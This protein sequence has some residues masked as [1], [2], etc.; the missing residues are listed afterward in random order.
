MSSNSDDL[1]IPERDSV[2]EKLRR[3]LFGD[4]IFISY[5][6]VD[7]TY[8][9]S[10][11]N[12]LTKNK[13]SCF[14]DQ[15][16]TPPGEE[17]P[18][19]LINTIKRCSTMVLIGSKNAADSDNVGL[20]VKE[21]LETDR[22]IIPITF[23]AD[24]LLVDTP[25]DSNRQ[26]LTGTL[27]Q[28]IWYSLIAGIAKTTEVLSALK[29]R[30]P[31]ENVIL[32]IVNAAEFRSRSKR[33]RKTFFATLGCVVLLSVIGFITFLFLSNQ[34][35]A[36]NKDRFDAETN[37]NL[38]KEGLSKAQ[39]ELSNTNKSLENATAS[40]KDKEGQLTNANI[41]LKNAATER[42]KVESRLTQTKQDLA[43]AETQTKIEQAKALRAEDQRIKAE[44]ETNKQKQETQKYTAINYFNTAQKL[45]SI[46]ADRSLL[47]AQESLKTL[48][49]KADEQSLY[50]LRLLQLTRNVKENFIN[51]AVTPDVDTLTIFS[52][53][54]N[55]AIIISKNILKVWDLKKGRE[56]PLPSFDRKSYKAIFYNKFYH[57]IFSP[58]EKY[59]AFF[60]LKKSTDGNNSVEDKFYLE[61]W[62]LETGENKL[63]FSHILFQNYMVH[64]FQTLPN[65]D[66]KLVTLDNESNLPMK[67]IWRFSPDSRSILMNTKDNI[68][69]QNKINSIIGWEVDS[70]NSEMPVENIRISNSRTNFAVSPDPNHNFVVTYEKSNSGNL[71]RFEDITKDKKISPMKVGWRKIQ[72]TPIFD[73]KLLLTLN[74][75]NEQDKNKWDQELVVHDLS[76]GEDSKY[77]LQTS[78]RPFLT[79]PSKESESPTRD[80]FL[81]RGFNKNKLFFSRECV[82]SATDKISKSNAD[83]ECENE[84]YIFDLKENKLENLTRPI[85]LGQKNFDQIKVSTFDDD[86][87]IITETI[88]NDNPSREIKVW[89]ATTGLLIR[90]PT[91]RRYSKVLPQEKSIITTPEEG[92][93]EIESILSWGREPNFKIDPSLLKDDRAKIRLNPDKKQFFIV[94]KNGISVHSLDNKDLKYQLSTDSYKQLSFNSDGSIISAV[95]VGVPSILKQWKL[96]VETGKFNG[97]KPV[98]L[99]YGKSL[100]KIGAE[101]SATLYTKDYKYGIYTIASGKSFFLYDAKSEEK[102]VNF[103]FTEL[104]DSFLAFALL[105]KADEVSLSPD[106]KEIK[107][108]LGVNSYSIKASGIRGTEI[109][110]ARDEFAG[111]DLTINFPYVPVKNYPDIDYSIFKVS[112]DGRLILT[113]EGSI[114]NLREIKSGEL[115]LSN[116]W[117]EDGRDFDFFAD[118]R[119]FYTIT[120]SGNVKS[121]YIG[122]FDNQTSKW[123]ENMANV[124]T[125]RQLTENSMQSL[126][127]SRDEYLCRREYFLED[128]K[129]AAG[130]NDEDA[131]FVLDNWNPFSQNEFLDKGKCKNLD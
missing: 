109:I 100:T 104:K 6:R 65:S 63:N 32:R 18:K 83:L 96:D 119:R 45:S 114:L 127:L 102:S 50:K 4:D 20:E 62:D 3:F 126:P 49:K 77:I 115:I 121:W 98:V 66:N 93:F 67:L 86:K 69:D 85:I 123:M 118:S 23:V 91:M 41:D 38:A 51:T 122:S 73:N 80:A 17:L 76:S 35:K 24:H 89:D 95:S 9:L 12:E 103:Y 68:I 120:K 108:Q 74:K 75:Q 31:S 43:T 97:L 15:W 131:Q 64:P 34:V 48:P 116:I 55:K 124:L 106:K 113:K 36:A 81:I 70:P 8:A 84:I 58:D 61:V 71:L 5:S 27:E 101:T 28:A 110:D 39:Q 78:S 129:R 79:E 54:G 88:D 29:S 13:L 10:L 92:L 56:I 112:P 1:V 107:L 21:F 40:L 7:S 16:G 57:P 87:F 19:E 14:L 72:S 82:I 111:K 52:E 130:N 99:V 26:N 117:F 44:E 2:V 25:D 125:G 42:K 59:I 11:A 53:K 37:A 47:W 22:P 30:K 33:L 105:L 46:D 94:D 60:A 90:Q 128:L